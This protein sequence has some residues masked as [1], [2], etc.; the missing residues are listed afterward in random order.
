MKRFNIR[1]L[2]FFLTISFFLTCSFSILA[3]EKRNDTKNYDFTKNWK[4]GGG[5]GL[6]FGSGY[7]D[8]MIAPSA[9][10]QFTPYVSAGI[11]LQG[12]YIKS[13]DRGYYYNAIKEYDSWIYGGSLIVLSNPI[14]QLQLSAELEQ[15]RVNNSYTYKDLTKR[16][17]NFWNTALFLG[18]GYVNGP[19]TIGI[20]YN[21]LYRE[22]DMVYGSGFMP[23]VRM[24]F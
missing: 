16:D 5:L 21:V 2:S 22:K 4:F 24:Y 14:P 15:L 11:G 9:I 12:S 3:Q 23:F 1:I 19:V 20:R 7:T 8:I 6:G 17:D 18:I 13:K 10:Y